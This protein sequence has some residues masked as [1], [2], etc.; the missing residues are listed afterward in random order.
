MPQSDR[1]PQI[2]FADWHAIAS[3]IA[4]QI[5]RA[6][7][8]QRPR[9]VGIS[10]SQGSGKST[11]A[12]FV[13]EHIKQ[14]GLQ[15]VTVSLDDF[16]LTKAQR[17][18]L[19]RTVHPL[20]RTR[21]VPGTHDSQWLG[22]VLHALQAANPAEGV[23]LE[24]P[25]FDKGMDDRSGQRQVRCQILVL[26]GWC[27]GVQAQPDVS[28]PINALER[29]ADTEGRWRSWVNEQTREHYE[30]LWQCIDYWVQLRPPGFAQV[31]QWRGEQEQQ[32]APDKQMDAQALQRFIDHYERLTRWQW[33]C[34][35]HQPGMR[36][37][38]GA[39]HNVVSVANLNN[40]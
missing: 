12:N 18:E 25:T 1:P 20:L 3:D 21:G 37:E 15:A 24:L 2:E 6:S 11:L 29:T 31:V 8:D 34:A 9:I 22:Q 23:T 35:P 33:A 16:Y 10:G 19:S 5:D 27:V 26:E 39:D 30:P 7:P 13:V 38:L 28:Q 4:E 32:I 36:V 17:I 40:H 14:R